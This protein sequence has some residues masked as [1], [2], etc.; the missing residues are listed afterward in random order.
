MGKFEEVRK[1]ISKELEW[2]NSLMREVLASD[3]A[4]L[5]RVVEENLRVKG[6]QIRPI[7]VI[8]SAEVSAPVDKSVIFAAAAIE[9]LH[10]ASLIHDDVLDESAKRRGV[11]TVNFLWD[12][13]VAVL[14]GDYYVSRALRCATETGNLSIVRTMSNLGT[15]LSMGEIDQ[16]DHARKHDISEHS[17]FEIIRRK[18]ASLFRSCVEVGCEA[19]N[20]GADTTAMLC[21]YAELLGLCFQIRDDIFDYGSDSNSVGKPTGN[22]LREGKVTLPLIHALS[23]DNS[24]ENAEMRAL[25]NK[26]F[27]D[28]EDIDKLIAYAIKHDG[29]EYAYSK[30]KQLRA[31]A[32]LIV[33]ALPMNDAVRSLEAI[34]DYTIERNS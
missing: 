32:S 5:N 22:D 34:F 6:K 26:E 25:L 33:S 31:E 28:T 16:I 27:L 10:N 3:N 19:V 13:Q 9:L 8:L 7:L 1:S 15:D 11:P 29:I 17:Y 21:K 24:A 30:M 20:A 2:L 23:S 14:T 18:T 12:N 4:F